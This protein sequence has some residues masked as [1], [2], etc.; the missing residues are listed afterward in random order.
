[1]RAELAGDSLQVECEGEDEGGQESQGGEAGGI[2]AVLQAVVTPVVVADAEVSL[3][4]V[5]VH[6][7]A[8]LVV[9]SQ[10]HKSD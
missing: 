9:V 3:S 4:S 1:M 8:F 6:F 5:T 10:Y 2:S 7:S